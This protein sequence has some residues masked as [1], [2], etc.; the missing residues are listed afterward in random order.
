MRHH[1]GDSEYD[2][3]AHRLMRGG[4]EVPLTPKARE[5]LELLLERRPNPATKPQIHDRLWPAIH[6]AE[7]NI[8]TLIHEL[9]EALLDDARK[10]RWLRT[11][12]GLG[13]ALSPDRSLENA[14]APAHAGTTRPPD[15]RLVVDRRVIRLAWGDNLL[16]RAE[17]AVELIEAPGV[18]RRH[19]IV[20]LAPGSATLLDC[21]SKN[22][23]YLN[24]ERIAEP[25]PLTDG[26]VIGLGEA[27][28][29][30]RELRQMDTDT[31]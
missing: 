15:A 28:L 20:R 11:V 7:V 31:L 9:R 16:G 17:E 26:D 6:V 3:A 30:Y 25:R 18:S 14:P 24:S 23:T 12:R 4:A 2:E 22:G 13:Y 21:G 1:F 8:H 10:P 27:Q 19:A 5:F 29:T